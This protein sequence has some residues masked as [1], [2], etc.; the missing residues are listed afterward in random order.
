MDGCRELGGKVE[1][2]KR[3]EVRR[4]MT[5]AKESRKLEYANERG[6]EQ[7]RR[8]KLATTPY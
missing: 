6:L 8:D 7:E 2:E 3:E 4:T 1:V 5:K